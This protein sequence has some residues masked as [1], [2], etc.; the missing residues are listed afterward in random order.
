MT[1]QRLGPMQALVSTHSS[2]PPGALSSAGPDM[3]ATVWVMDGAGWHGIIDFRSDG[4][5]LTE[6]GWGRWEQRGTHVAM[7]NDYDGFRFVVELD[8]AGSV[9]NGTRM[10][11]GIPVLG[12]YMGAY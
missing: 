11:D 4:R 3:K 12:R 9:F 1:R 10:P 8:A 6:W 7:K 2:S 5:Y